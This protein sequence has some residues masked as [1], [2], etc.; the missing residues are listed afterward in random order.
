VK[1]LAWLHY[2]RLGLHVQ[3][4]FSQDWQGVSMENEPSLF[5]HRMEKVAMEMHNGKKLVLEW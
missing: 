5:S 2:R 3:I 1:Q 4:Y